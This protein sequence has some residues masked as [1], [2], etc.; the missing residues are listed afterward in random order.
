[1][2]IVCFKKVIQKK[3]IAALPGLMLRK[4][5]KQKARQSASQLALYD[6][7]KGKDFTNSYRKRLCFVCYL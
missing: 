3:N 1:M 5:C 4:S 2:H 6:L 7:V